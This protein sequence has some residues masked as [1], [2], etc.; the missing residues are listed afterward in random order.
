M[1]IRPEDNEGSAEAAR[2]AEPDVPMVGG[3]NLGIDEDETEEAIPLKPLPQPNVPSK[4]E[5]DRHQI[6]HLPY[7]S[8]CP[9][10]IRGRGKNAAHRK[11]DKEIVRT[12]PRLCVDYSFVGQRPEVQ[13]GEAARVLQADDGG[14]ADEKLLENQE[15]G[16]FVDTSEQKENEPVAPMARPCFLFW[17]QR[18]PGAALCT[19]C[20]YHRKVQL[21]T[22]RLR[23]SKRSSKTWVTDVLFSRWTGSHR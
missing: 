19:Q 21:S 9:H 2:I 3:E 16:D 22:T 12:I 11:L 20:L 5:Y 14:D 15:P 6:T 8:W 23:C 7:R 13:Q 17:Q 18:I 10:C 4:A 1:A